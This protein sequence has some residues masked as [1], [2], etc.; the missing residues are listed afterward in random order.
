MSSKKMRSSLLLWC[1]IHLQLILRIPSE[2]DP[3]P[4][5][6][7]TTTAVQPP[8]TT[9][10]EEEVHS[11]S[12]KKKGRVQGLQARRPPKRSLPLHLKH[13]N[14]KRRIGEKCGAMKGKVPPYLSSLEYVPPD[15]LYGFTSQAPLTR[16]KQYLSQNGQWVL[17]PT[18]S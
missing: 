11:P 10:E 14:R 9:T 4:P 18:H 5:S 17:R 13:G 7:S 3:Q 8:S 15:L 2:V 16:L 6:T 12:P 1:G